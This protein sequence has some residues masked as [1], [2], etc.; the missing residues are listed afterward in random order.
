MLI[1]HL[2]LSKK[3][4]YIFNCIEFHGLLEKIILLQKNIPNGRIVTD[5]A[6][7][8]KNFLPLLLCTFTFI[9]NITVCVSDF[10][11]G[12]VPLWLLPNCPVQSDVCMDLLNLR[13]KVR[14]GFTWPFLLSQRFLKL[15]CWTRLRLFGNVK[16][17]KLK[18]LRNKV[19]SIISCNH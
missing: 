18:K 15:I 10:I 14:V 2:D 19:S 5:V 13:C 11:V 8:L 16:L 12:L 9:S 4:Q 1:C 3:K 6:E 17:S 7:N